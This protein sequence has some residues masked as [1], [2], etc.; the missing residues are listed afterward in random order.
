MASEQSPEN[1]EFL[2]AFVG[3][4]EALRSYARS[5]LPNWEV[6]DEVL[7]EASV[8]MWRKFDQLDSIEGFLPWAKVIV[9][10][11]SLK[12]RRTVA[13]DKLWFS[14][15]LIEIMADEDAGDE[16][17]ETLNSE[18]DALDT[19]LGKLNEAQ[20]DLVLLPY[21][22]HGAVTQLAE[23]SKK[24]VNSYYK[25]IGRI[26]DNLANCIEMELNQDATS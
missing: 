1:E 26:R 15:D 25:K 11:E 18:R 4:E 8:V 20:R 12:A 2:R 22:D 7:Q 3:H 13:R 17:D 5:L 19:C 16:S 23:Q 24:S 10:F 9:R 21:R 6:V 14:E